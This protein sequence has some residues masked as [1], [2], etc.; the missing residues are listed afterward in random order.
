MNIAESE[1][2]LETYRHDLDNQGFGAVTEALAET[3]GV[4]KA[5]HGCLDGTH[6]NSD[7]NQA[8]GAELNAFG[9]HIQ[10]PDERDENETDEEVADG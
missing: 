9:F 8:V 5:I 1:A 7:T 2:I 4:L 10:G 6:W 3:L